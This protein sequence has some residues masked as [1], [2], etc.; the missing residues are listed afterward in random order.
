MGIRDLADVLSSR[1]SMAN[2]AAFTLVIIGVLVTSN[3][4]FLETLASIAAGYLFGSRTVK[5]EKQ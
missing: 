1:T 2:A 5:Q 4:N 3:Q